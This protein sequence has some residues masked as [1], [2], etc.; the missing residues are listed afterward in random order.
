MRKMKTFQV[1]LIASILS[2]LLGCSKSPLSSNSPVKVESGY[3]VT[4]VGDTTHSD[5]Y[6]RP[7]TGHSFTYFD[8]T[9]VMKSPSGISI[10]DDSSMTLIVP[11]SCWIYVFG[12]NN[13]VAFDSLWVTKD[14]V[15]RP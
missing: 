3:E 5:D 1:V 7:I 4:L 15:W 6:Y 9:S 14:T 8:F 12:G 13:S 10:L 11:K 2:V